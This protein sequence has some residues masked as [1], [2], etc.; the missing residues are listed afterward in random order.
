MDIG[1]E[2]GSTSRVRQ[3]A[4]AETHWL[5]LVANMPSEEDKV[6]Y[7]G[8]ETSPTG[9]MTDGYFVRTRG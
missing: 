9:N 6:V 7:A 2:S 5:C 3:E 1:C 8:T 4:E